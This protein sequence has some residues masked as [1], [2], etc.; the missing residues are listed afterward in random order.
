MQFPIN[1]AFT[2]QCLSNRLDS[3]NVGFHNPGE[4]IREVLLV[5]LNMYTQNILINLNCYL[6]EFNNKYKTNLSALCLVHLT[7]RISDLH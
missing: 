6:K 3:F 7:R 5:C 4:T 1:F 2:P